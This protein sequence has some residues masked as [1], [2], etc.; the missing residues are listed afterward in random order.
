MAMS[1]KNEKFASA[2]SRLSVVLTGTSITQLDVELPNGEQVIF[3]DIPKG[4]EECAVFIYE[5][6]REQMNENDIDIYNGEQYVNPCQT[7]SANGISDGAKLDARKQL[8]IPLSVELLNGSDPIILD[9]VA[10][11][12]DCANKIYSAMYEKLGITEPDRPRYTRKGGSIRG[13]V[14]APRA[15]PKDIET[16]HINY[17]EDF[18]YPDRTLRFQGIS[19]GAELVCTI[20]SEVGE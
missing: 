20:Q 2:L 19:A 17:G 5:E 12:S 1:A 16:I 4:E 13:Y 6:V 7:L 9:D 11:E 15:S 3:N 14:H 10:A 8:P 18:V